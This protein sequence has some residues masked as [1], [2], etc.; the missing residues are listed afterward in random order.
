MSL[1]VVLAI[2]GFLVLFVPR[3]NTDA[4][5]LVDYRT[6]LARAR[7]DAPFAVAA[8]VGLSDRWRPTSVRYDSDDLSPAWHLG[9]VTP[10]D[11]YAAIEQSSGG[12]RTFVQKM[13]GNGSLEGTIE[14]DGLSWERRLRNSRLQRSLVL[15]RGDATTIVTGTASWHEL[16]ELATALR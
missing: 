11:A 1:I 13:T 15:T 6:E 8:P 4:V 10:Q 16:R 14:I 2:V 12:N 9:F 3:P 5:R 7:A